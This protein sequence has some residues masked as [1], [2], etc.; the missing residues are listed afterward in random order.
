MSKED[1]HKLREY[2]RNTGKICLKICS[3][4]VAVLF[5]FFVLFLYFT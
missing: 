3:F 1:K 5:V 4:S 2:G